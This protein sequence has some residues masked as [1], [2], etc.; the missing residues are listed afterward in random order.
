M[1]AL[2]DMMVLETNCQ[3]LR[4]L[5][6]RP[7][8]IYGERD[9]Q[10]IPGALAVL[11]D[12]NNHFQLGDN[13]NPHDSI[14]VENAVSAHIVAAKALLRDNTSNSKVDG[15]TFSITNDNPIPF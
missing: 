8:L 1:K 15:E 7:P 5:C 14:Y 9:S 4:T 12:K 13:I 2:A 6:L 3:E 10:L 11:R